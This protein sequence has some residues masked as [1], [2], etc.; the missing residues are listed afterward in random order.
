MCTR[1]VRTG[2]ALVYSPDG[3]ISVTL[4]LGIFT[5]ST[6]AVD[7]G[8]VSSAADRPQRV[9]EGGGALP[10]ALRTGEKRGI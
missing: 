3:S 10:A 4:S 6:E 5:R 9:R 1:S 8:E 7:D 2:D